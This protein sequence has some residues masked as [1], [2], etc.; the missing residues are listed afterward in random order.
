MSATV[1]AKIRNTFNGR[2]KDSKRNFYAK[3]RRRKEKI[4]NG[5]H[6]FLHVEQKTEKDV[7][8]ELAPTI[9]VPY[10]V[11]EIKPHTVVI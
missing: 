3:L 10:Q 5:D 2:S 11:I 9:T 6:V 8:N 4:K 7:Q 1:F